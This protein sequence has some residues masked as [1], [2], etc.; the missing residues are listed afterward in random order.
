MR[1]YTLSRLDVLDEFGN[2]GME[3]LAATGD[4]VKDVMDITSDIIIDTGYF[5]QTIL[6]GIEQGKPIEYTGKA[7]QRFVVDVAGAVG[8]VRGSVGIGKARMEKVMAESAEEAKKIRK[9]IKT[10]EF[11]PFIPK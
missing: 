6:Y 4:T 7:S 2:A 8:A 5:M 10:Y 11:E 3:I 9:E 1:S